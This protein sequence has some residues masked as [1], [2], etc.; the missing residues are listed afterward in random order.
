MAKKSTITSLLMS[1]ITTS[2]AAVYFRIGVVPINSNN[3]A[4]DG[5][6]AVESIK[7]SRMAFGQ[8]AQ[9]SQPCYAIAFEGGAEKLL[10]PHTQFSQVTISVTDKEESIDTPELPE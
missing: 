6:G 9:V 3:E 8:G 5:M 10:V 7:H 4:V 2:F 1:N